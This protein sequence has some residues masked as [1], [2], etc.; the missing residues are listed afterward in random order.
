[1]EGQR[2]EGRV[3]RPDGSLPQLLSPS[4]LVNVLM[5]RGNTESREEKNGNI[6]KMG[7]D[8]KRERKVL[9]Q[10]ASS[11]LFLNEHVI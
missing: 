5:K 6:T 3:R 2:R 8:V 7:E 1:M 10:N 4:Q 9:S 11:A